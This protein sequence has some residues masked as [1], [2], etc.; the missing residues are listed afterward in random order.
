MHGPTSGPERTRFPL[1]GGTSFDAILNF[2]PF[3]FAIDL[4]LWVSVTAAGVELLGVLL[5]GSLSGPNPWRVAGSAEFRILGIK[6]SFALD[7]SFGE[8]A[9]E[10]PPEEADR[11]ALLEAA[12]APTTPGRAGAGGSAFR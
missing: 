12:L 1:E 9:N 3:G 5:S 11:A 6:K 10:G 4:R 7:E 2:D 8:L